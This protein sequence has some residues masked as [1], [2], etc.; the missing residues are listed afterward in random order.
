M[1]RCGGFHPDP[2]ASRVGPKA[3]WIVEGFASL[4]GQFE[5]DF[6]RRKVGFGT[7][8]LEDA[9]L[10]VSATKEQLIDWTRL[11]KMS[12]LDF[13]RMSMVTRET[14]IASTMRMGAAHRAR[15]LNLFYSQSAMLCR[16]LYEAENARFRK[17]LLDYVAAFYT[18]AVD[19]LDFAT[20]FGVTPEEL[21]PKV[22]EYARTLTQ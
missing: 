21:G 22:V 20:A 3:F 2:L 5:F 19:K 7:A 1:D 15:R 4:V 13:Q 12:R 10:V 17:A 8:N 6:V 14:A 9:D 16:Y 18:G 11:A